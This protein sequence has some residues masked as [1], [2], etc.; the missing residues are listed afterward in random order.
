METILQRTIDFVDESFGFKGRHYER[1]LYWLLVL[2][3]NADIA[4]QIAAYSH[5]IQRAFKRAEILDKVQNSGAGFMDNEML[6]IHQEDGAKIVGDFLKTEN[7]PINIISDVKHLISRHEIGGDEKQNLIKDADS[8]SFFECNTVDFI[9]K[10][11]PIFGKQKVKEKFDWMYNRITSEKAKGIV[12]DMYNS[13]II[14]LK[15]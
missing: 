5:D 4:M 6:T 9:E 11:V 7:V 12:I 14:K 3:P 1:T 15:N 2:E 13:A 8:I 10:Y